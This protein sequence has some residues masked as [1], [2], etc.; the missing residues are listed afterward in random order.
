MNIFIDNATFNYFTVLVICIYLY[1][2]FILGRKAIN[3][4][5]IGCGDGFGIID[6]YFVDTRIVFAYYLR[7]DLDADSLV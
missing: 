1:R 6:C 7:F 5:A 2:P 3:G 4:D